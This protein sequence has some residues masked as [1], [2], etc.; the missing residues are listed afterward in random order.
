MGTRILNDMHRVKDKVAAAFGAM[1]SDVTGQQLFST[2]NAHSV[3]LKALESERSS[4]ALARRLWLSFAGAGRD[5]LF[6]HDLIEVL[7]AERTELAEEIFHILDRDDNGDVSLDEMTYLI[8]D[9][10][11][12]RKDRA[13]SMQDISQAIAVL[14]RLLSLVVLIGQYHSTY[15]V[16]APTDIACSHR[17]HLRNVL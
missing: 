5:V 2:T 1:A 9:A 6:K 15:V 10:G 13:A 7:G 17:L 11:N 16:M 8:V 3:V 12:E 4:K 14:D